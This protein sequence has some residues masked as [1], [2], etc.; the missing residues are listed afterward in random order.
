M[1]EGTPK[2]RNI[3][4]EEGSKLPQITL[5]TLLAIII[6]LFVIG[7]EYIS[8]DSKGSEEVTSTVPDTTSK[9]TSLDI[10]T[11]PLLAE[12]DAIDKSQS[13]ETPE[14]SQVEKVTPDPVETKPEQ[15]FNP[16]DLGGIEITH[17][18]K[19][20]ETFYGIANQ[21][22]LQS[23]TLKAL[24]PQINNVTADLKAGV[25]KLNVRVQAVHTVGAGDVL[26]VVAR[27]YKISLEQLMEA[28]GKTRNFSERGEK[29]IIPFGKQK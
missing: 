9:L 19:S 14:V 2:K 26:R 23:E 27:K 22:N 29:L 12:P 16:A 24:N 6:A 11:I 20:G 21:Y 15:K 1:E 10:S 17:T 4:P 13:D 3:R 7:Y 18:V 25:T 5:L 28:N 8:D